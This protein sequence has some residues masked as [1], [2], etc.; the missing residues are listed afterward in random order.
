MLNHVKDYIIEH[1]HKPTT[2]NT[3]IKYLTKFD[4]TMLTQTIA[5]AQLIIHYLLFK[6]L[7]NNAMDIAQ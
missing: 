5:D 6:E 3:L 1:P 2:I 4:P 7:P